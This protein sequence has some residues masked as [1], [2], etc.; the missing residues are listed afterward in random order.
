LSK[1]SYA[2]EMLGLAGNS[3]VNLMSFDNALNR[4][5]WSTAAKKGQ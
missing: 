3:G 1:N 4:I 2:L 5:H